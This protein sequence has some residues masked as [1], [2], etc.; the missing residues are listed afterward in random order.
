MEHRLLYDVEF[1]GAALRGQ[2]AI[3]K[4]K[5]RRVPSRKPDTPKR[6]PDKALCARYDEL[7]YLPKAVEDAEAKVR[8]N[9]TAVQAV[10]PSITSYI[11]N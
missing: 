6:M 10:D 2:G 1:D 8:T 5:R 11:R 9:Q 7:L 3:L 4:I